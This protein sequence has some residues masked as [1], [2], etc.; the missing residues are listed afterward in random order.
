M[1]IERTWTNYVDQPPIGYV[2]RNC[3]LF[4]VCFLC[5]IGTNLL[6]GQ[7]ELGQSHAVY[8]KALALR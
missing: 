1:A 8:E 3:L 6:E 7:G 5:K 4:S 2:Q